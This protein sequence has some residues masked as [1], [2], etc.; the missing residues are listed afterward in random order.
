MLREFLLKQR[1]FVATVIDDLVA[2]DL[3]LMQERDQKAACSVF[4][5]IELYSMFCHSSL[6]E[7][8]FI[9]HINIC[10]YITQFKGVQKFLFVSFILLKS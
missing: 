9:I 3:H 7:F 1:I 6:L 2:E 10:M 8:I 5:C 4:S